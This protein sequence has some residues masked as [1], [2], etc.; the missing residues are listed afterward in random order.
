MAKDYYRVLGIQRDATDEEIKKAYRKLAL[1]FHPD[2][3]PDSNAE[4]RFKEIGR[5]YEVLSDKKKRDTYDRYG[6]D[7]LRQGG[8]S[9]SRTTTFTNQHSYGDG[10]AYDGYQNITPEEL[11]SMFFGGG[12]GSA[13]FTSRRWQSQSSHRPR[14][15]TYNNSHHSQQHQ[16]GTD[17][18]SNTQQEVSPGLNL[19]VQ[20]LPVLVLISLSL[21]SYWLQTDP[22]YSLHPTT[23]YLFRRQI[24]KYGIEY[25]VRDDFEKQYRG[26]DLRRV[27]SQVFEDYLYE[28][29]NRCLREKN[30]KE[31]MLYR[32]QYV[33]F[34]EKLLEEARNIKTASC[35]QYEKLRPHLRH[36]LYT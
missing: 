27:E 10:R 15:Y 20:L 13:N 22:P 30:Y 19:L 29:R 3:N 16:A 2:K 7:G 34:S 35:T 23:K 6:E 8:S 17:G 14:Q 32:A 36:G 24:E 21:A 26:Q 25:Y 31:N 11:F 12:L 5:A 33:Y 28:L 1:K 18:S 4:E 9:S